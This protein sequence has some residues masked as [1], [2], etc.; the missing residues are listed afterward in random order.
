[1]QGKTT[2]GKKR[3]P[4]W[5]KV[6]AQH[7]EL[8]PACEVCGSVK[9]VEVH[10]IV[11]FSFDSSKE[12]DPTN[13]ISLCEFKKGGITCHLLVGH[14]GSYFKMNPNVKEDAVKVKAILANSVDG[15]KDE[16]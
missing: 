13:L 2:M 5:P 12:L 11:P 1:M 6:R 8:F 14:G 15:K 4:Q 16:V 9:K 7:L 10:H 3:S